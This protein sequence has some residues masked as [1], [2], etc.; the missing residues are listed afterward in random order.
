LISGL[1]GFPLNAERKN[2]PYINILDPAIPEHKR[3][4]FKNTTPVLTVR[5]GADN[6]LEAF[7]VLLDAQ[8]ACII[9]YI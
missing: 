9:Y 8:K 6:L 3:E 4:P 7:L 2:Q 5:S 1:S